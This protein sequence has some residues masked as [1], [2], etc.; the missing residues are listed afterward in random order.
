MQPRPTTP[1]RATINNKRSLRVARGPAAAC[2][3]ICRPTFA[4]RPRNDAAEQIPLRVYR[5]RPVNNR[6]DYYYTRRTFSRY[7]KKNEE[8]KNNYTYAKNENKKNPVSHAPINRDYRCTSMGR[9]GILSLKRKYYVFSMY[10]AFVYARVF[11]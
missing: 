6:L 11:I 2:A 7:G 4:R 5:A 1:V 3:S 10:Y 8:K 9:G